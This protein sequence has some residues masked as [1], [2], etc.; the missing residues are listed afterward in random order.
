MY[1][2]VEGTTLRSLHYILSVI[3]SPYSVALGSVSA[4]C[5]MGVHIRVSACSVNTDYEVMKCFIFFLFIVFKMD[6]FS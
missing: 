2:R 1:W 3:A 6:K 4:M 5:C